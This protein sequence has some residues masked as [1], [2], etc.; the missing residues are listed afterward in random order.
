MRTP[1]LRKQAYD[2][3]MGLGW[4][5][6][7]VGSIRTAA[8]GGTFAGHILLLELVPEKN[9]AMAILTNAGTGWRLIQD[10]ER[11]ALEAYHGAAFRT[12]QAISH[13]G[14]NETLPLVTPLAQQPDLAPYVGRFVRPMNDVVVRAERGV[15]HA[16]AGPA[17]GDPSP[18]MPLHGPTRRVGRPEEGAS[19]GHRDAAANP[20]WI[21]VTGRI[22]RQADARGATLAVCR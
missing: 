21:R 3:D 9:F 14:L 13:R 17:T 8:H 22:A 7:T 18:D 1:Q 2:D 10:V 4:H 15:L 19:I 6:R 12:N 16:Q 5:L 11:A 20:W